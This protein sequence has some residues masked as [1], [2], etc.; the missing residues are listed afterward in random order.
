MVHIHLVLCG[1]EASLI[2]PKNRWGK[3]HVL[4][5]HI[6]WIP[7]DDVKP[8]A[9]SKHPLRVE[10]VGGGVLVVGIPVGQFFGGLA[11]ETVGA[12]QGADLSAEF[13]VEFPAFGLRGWSAG[14]EVA[15]PDLAE[16]GFLGV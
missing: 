3:V 7:D 13:G 1:I 8:F 10:E 14:G 4:Q 16:F 5:E 15:F 12:E 11:G 2:V 6:R 9:D